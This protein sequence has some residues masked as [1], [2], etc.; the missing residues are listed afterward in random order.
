[1]VSHI[2]SYSIVLKEEH[3]SLRSKEYEEL[4]NRTHRKSGPKKGKEI[5]VMID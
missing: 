2:K 5:I 3:Q 4:K 1:M